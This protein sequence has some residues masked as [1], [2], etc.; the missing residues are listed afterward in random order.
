MEMTTGNDESNSEIAL[1]KPNHH[2]EYKLEAKD[3]AHKRF[4]KYSFHMSA[5]ENS[6]MKLQD[7]SASDYSE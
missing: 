5:E 7:T 6:K 2:S 1:T 3:T 4:Y